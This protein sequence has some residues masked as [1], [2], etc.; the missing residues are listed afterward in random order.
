MKISA[1]NMHNTLAVLLT[2]SALFGSVAPASASEGQG[3]ITGTGGVTD[4]F[5]DEATL[6]SGSRYW[7]S[8]ASGLVQ[9]IL[10]REFIG[11]ISMDCAY[12]GDTTYWVKEYQKRLGFTG[13]DVDGVVGPA[14]WNRIDNRLVLGDYFSD[15]ARYVRYNAIG[16]ADGRLI[17]LIE[18]TGDYYWR[19]SDQAPLI[20]ASYTDVSSDC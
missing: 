12:G 2:M 18:S 6:W 7:H 15:T 14:T 20:Q 5:S 13:S 1:R 19:R 9:Y 16:G 8:N 3:K 4:D 10:S 17:R 11:Q